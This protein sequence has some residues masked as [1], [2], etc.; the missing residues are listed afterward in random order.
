LTAVEKIR[1]E[2]DNKAKDLEKRERLREKNASRWKE[3][4]DKKEIQEFEEYR[5][6]KNSQRLPINFIEGVNI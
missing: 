6:T 5:D 3:I 4:L 1:K 2:Q